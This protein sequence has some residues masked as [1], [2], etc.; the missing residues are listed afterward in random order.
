MKYETG[1]EKKF[2]SVTRAAALAGRLTRAG[3]CACGRPAALVRRSHRWQ[4]LACCVHCRATVAI[5]AGRDPKAADIN[6]ATRRAA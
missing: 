3:L 4:R 1:N 6:K 5:G 2:E